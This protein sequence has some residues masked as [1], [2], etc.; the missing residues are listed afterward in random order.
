M[1]IGNPPAS[2]AD[3]AVSLTGS[4]QGG[5]RSKITYTA[6]IKNNGPGAASGI[7]VAAALPSNLT[8]VGTNG[9][10]RVGTTRNL[11]CAVASLASGASVTR[12]FTGETGMLAT[13][14][15]V[16][17]AQRT[18]SSPADPVASNDKATRSCSGLLGMVRC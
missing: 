6:T 4:V 1:V 14:S 12:T 2:A 15:F 3:I 13:G 5:A 9:C 16:G 11:N 10:T 18:A 8:Y 17:T 7:N